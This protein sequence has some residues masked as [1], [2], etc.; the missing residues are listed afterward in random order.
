M[1]PPAAAAPAPKAPLPEPTR[2]DNAD[3]VIAC[4]NL[5]K[6]NLHAPDD[7]EFPGILLDTV[8][9]PVFDDDGNGVWRAWVKAPNLFNVRLRKGFICRYNSRTTKLL[10]NLDD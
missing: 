10:V 8:P 7:A 6:K 1:S 9:P 3:M 4:R 5:V 2:I